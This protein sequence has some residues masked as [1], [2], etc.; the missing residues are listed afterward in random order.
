MKKTITKQELEVEIARLREKL[1]GMERHCLANSISATL[2]SAFPAI[3]LVY[4]IAKT[5]DVLPQITHDLAGKQTSVTISIAL[6]WVLTA[7]ASAL[8]W[9]ERRQKQSEIVR[10]TKELNECRKL[11]DK[12]R[13]TS[14]LT[15]KG[16]THK[17]D[18]P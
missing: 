6:S 18:L 1:K 16:T 5:T 10:L 11:I 9:K 14:G 2:T 7:G 4:L 8:W 12:R 15:T 17:S 3:V 13:Q